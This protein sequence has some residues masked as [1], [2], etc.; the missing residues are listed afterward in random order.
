MKTPLSEIEQETLRTRGL[1][2]ANEIAYKENGLVY[3]EDALAGKKRIVNSSEMVNE[4]KNIL[5]G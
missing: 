1:I 3:A 5:L 2:K 4:S